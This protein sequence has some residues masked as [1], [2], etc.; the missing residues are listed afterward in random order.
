MD[1]EPKQKAQFSPDTISALVT[2]GQMAS[3]DAFAIASGVPGTTLMEAAGTAVAQAVLSRFRL[4]PVLLLCG[5]GNNGGDG[6]VAARHVMQRG[7]PVRVALLGALAD[8]RGDAA[9][10]AGL[11]PGPVEAFESLTL[12]D[13]AIVIDAVF[14]AGLSRAVDGAA[15]RVLTLVKD[16]GL[17]VVA[18][19]VPSGVSGDTGQVQGMAVPAV[20]TVTFF[21]PKPGH[22]LLPGRE[23]CGE[24]IVVD[25]GIGA[26]ALTNAMTVAA[27]RNNPALWP[28]SPR[29]PSTRDHKYSRG[30]V[31]IIGGAMTGATRL[32]AM[33]AQRMGAG[34]VTLVVPATTALVHRL[35]LPSA[36]VV[37][38]D[39]VAEIVAQAGRATVDAII[40][41]PGGGATAHMRTVVQAV[42]ALGRPTVVDAD[43]LSAFAEDPQ[44][45]MAAVHPACVLTPHAGE[46]QRVFP[47]RG[48]KLSAARAAAAASGTI[49]LYKGS[50]TVIAAPDGR[51]V[52][53]D[54]APPQLAVAGSGDVLAGLIGAVLA[55][56][57][58]AM[59]AACCGAWCHGALATRLGAGLLAEDL[60][61]ALPGLLTELYARGP[62]GRFR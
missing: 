25:I 37:E 18:V 49:L 42:L 26:A 22:L 55:Q 51:A 33:A 39:S 32:A 5:P 19:D 50:D 15:R 6:F 31:L 60:P 35:A 57:A 45:L 36:I 16:A 23:L 17:P 4:A 54:N 30:H 13:A 10:A 1:D 46:F 27:W 48:D 21:R 58:E 56:G 59:A 44:S 38:A 3:A 62:A 34:L 14:G 8:L 12:D 43:A 2:S 11:W 52:I 53:N 61:P 24:R 28:G 29:S 7:W 20:A 41:G 40:I 47:Y 9:W